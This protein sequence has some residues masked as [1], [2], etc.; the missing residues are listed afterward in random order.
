MP[1]PE[2]DTVRE[3]LDECVFVGHD[4][5]REVPEYRFP[6]QE[7]PAREALL[8]HRGARGPDVAWPLHDG[9]RDTIAHFSRHPVTVPMTKEESGGFS[10]L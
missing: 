2:R 3:Q 4:M 9:P 7:S 10:H 8:R 5:T 1:L 6:A